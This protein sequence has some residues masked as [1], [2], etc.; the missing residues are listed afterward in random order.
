MFA[1]C[2]NKIWSRIVISF[3]GEGRY[4]DE[5]KTCNVMFSKN[6]NKC[7]IPKELL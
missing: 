1:K 4:Q 7:I 3:G 6:N 5:G 2:A